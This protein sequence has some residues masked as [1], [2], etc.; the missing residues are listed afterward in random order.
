M[1][2]KSDL[3]LQ[4]IDRQGNV[5]VEQDVA[6]HLVNHPYPGGPPTSR[7][8]IHNSILG[9]INTVIEKWSKTA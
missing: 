3:K 5:L 4:V 7:M 2:S 9:R 8:M 6:P 1:R